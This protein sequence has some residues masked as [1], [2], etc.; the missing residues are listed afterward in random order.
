[1]AS[2]W[3]ERRAAEGMGGNGEGWG[4]NGEGWGGRGGA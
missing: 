3:M 2:N 4:G 1:M